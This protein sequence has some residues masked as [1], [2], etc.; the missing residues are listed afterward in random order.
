MKF[1][2]TW[3]SSPGD[4]KF[5]GRLCKIYC[6]FLYFGGSNYTSRTV[7]GMMHYFDIKSYPSKR[8]KYCIHYFRGNY[9]REAI[10]RERAITRGNTVLSGINV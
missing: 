3:N 1:S 10:I 8:G 2:I 7:I 9:S 4:N 6:E 5:R